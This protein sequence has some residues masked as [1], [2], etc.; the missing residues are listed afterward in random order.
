MHLQLI[1]SR[2]FTS[3]HWN[4]QTMEVLPPFWIWQCHVVARRPIRH[5]SPVKGKERSVWREI[6]W[7]NVAQLYYR[8]TGFEKE[9][10]KQL[11]KKIFR[12][13]LYNFLLQLTKAIMSTNKSREILACRRQVLSREQREGERQRARVNTRRASEDDRQRERVRSR[14][15][16]QNSSEE[17]RPV[18]R[19]RARRRRENYSEKRRQAKRDRA[20]M[21]RQRQR[22]RE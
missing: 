7:R 15:R 20:R 2:N 8:A 22:E 17:S 18:E 12:Q 19:V 10:S 9:I 14:R 21:S 4:K 3:F 6:G 13:S 5:F 16:R 1:L 11:S